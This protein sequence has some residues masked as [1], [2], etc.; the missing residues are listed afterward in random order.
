[1]SRSMD[2]QE[3]GAA[4]P[5]RSFPHREPTPA[6]P[7]R[8]W[9]FLIISVG[10][11]LAAWFMF[12]ALLDQRQSPHTTLVEL[13]SAA[14][15][16]GVAATLVSLLGIRSPTFLWLATAGFASAVALYLA[17]HVLMFSGYGVTSLRE[18]ILAVGGFLLIAGPP[19]LV[20][21]TLARACAWLARTA[22]W[23]TPWRRPPA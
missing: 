8:P 14:A 20:G 4:L 21:L 5:G 18:L 13:A 9:T 12:D 19:V 16:V 15:L 6:G 2:D 22:H 23:T 7:G 11:L 3:S 10:T 17:G 1:M